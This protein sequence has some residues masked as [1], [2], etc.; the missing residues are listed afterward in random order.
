MNRHGEHAKLLA[1]VDVGY[2]SC[3]IGVRLAAMRTPAIDRKRFLMRP[4]ECDGRDG[5]RTPNALRPFRQ[6]FRPLFDL[7][8]LAVVPL[9]FGDEELHHLFKVGVCLGPIGIGPIG[10]FAFEH[11]DQV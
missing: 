9:G 5:N 10:C 8:D 7:D 2:P 6:A 1:S 11:D 3:V 4:G